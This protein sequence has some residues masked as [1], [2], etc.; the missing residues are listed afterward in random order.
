MFSDN[1]KKLFYLLSFIEGG[2][3]MATEL[4]GAKMLAPYFGS[5]LY[6]WAT[7]LAM[8]LGG[9]ALGYFFGGILSF[10]NK[11]NKNLLFYI[12]LLA[13]LFTASMP[14]ISKGILPMLENYS[15]LPAIILSS[16]FIL[17]PPVFMMGM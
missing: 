13:A 1:N 8:T 12:L 17:L 4:L 2:C 15:L 11:T 16:A 3:V 5:S 7:V 10:K 14:L 9:L 6:V